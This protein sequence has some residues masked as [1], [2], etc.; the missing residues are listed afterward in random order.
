M[1]LG[2]LQAGENSKNMP[3]GTPAY[4]ELFTS[5]FDRAGAGF[6]I[7]FVQVRL[8]EFPQSVDEYDAYL[9]TGSAA[10]VYDELDW[11]APLEDFIRSAYAAGK[12]LAGICFGHQ[13]IANA[14]GG[15]AEKSEKG[16]GCG[17]RTLPII[18]KGHIFTQDDQD[19]TLLYMHQ[20]QVTQAPPEAT[21][22]IG[23]DFCPV[24][25]FAIGDQVLCFQGHPEF[26]PQVIA[27]ITDLRQDDIGAERAAQC[28]ASLATPHEGDDIGRLI[29]AFLINA[30][31][32]TE[33]AATQAV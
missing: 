30:A 22:L 14:L 29:T 24:A 28:H 6:D 13:V 11:I 26:T 7:T 15:K 2:I 21:V 5:L 23:D 16:W 32:Q 20:D 9:V 3:E 8:G 17:V 25:S 18:D 12:P 19:S 33:Q 10:G 31:K 4:P 1:R 27:G